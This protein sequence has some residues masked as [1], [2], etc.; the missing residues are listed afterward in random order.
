MLFWARDARLSARLRQALSASR[1][2]RCIAQGV[3]PDRS[4]VRHP[5]KIFNFHAHEFT[6][7]LTA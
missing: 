2:R 4:A 3:P 7:Y 6:F 1:R 5:A